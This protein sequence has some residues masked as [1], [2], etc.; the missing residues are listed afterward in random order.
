MVKNNM[1]ERLLTLLQSTTYPM[2]NHLIQEYDSLDKLRCI[3][4]AIAERNCRKLR[5]G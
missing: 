2:R 3:G 4:A 5:A 1:K